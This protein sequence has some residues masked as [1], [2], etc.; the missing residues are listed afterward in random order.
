MK[1][2]EDIEWST[3]IAVGEN[4]MLPFFES[5]SPMLKTE[6]ALRS[7]LWGEEHVWTKN[8]ESN[9]SMHKKANRLTKLTFTRNPRY[10]VSFQFLQPSTLNKSALVLVLP[11]G[12]VYSKQKKREMMEDQLHRNKLKI[13]M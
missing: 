4:T 7:S 3:F 1:E 10:Q 2:G 13:Y 11:H 8:M 6:L 5:C 12:T 9:V